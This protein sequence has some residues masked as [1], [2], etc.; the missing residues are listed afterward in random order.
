METRGYRIPMAV[1]VSRRTG[2]VTSIQWQE[3]G[4]EEEF[5]SIVDWMQKAGSMTHIEIEKAQAG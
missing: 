5:Q 3:G 1:T 2:E 4:T